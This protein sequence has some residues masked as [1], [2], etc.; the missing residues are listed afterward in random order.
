MN[1]YLSFICVIAFSSS[2]LGQIDYDK[3]PDVTQTYFINDVHIQK[4][5]TDSFG[6]GD[7]LIVD[8]YIKQVAKSISPPADA[9]IIEA[10]SAY[11]YSA[12]IDA[13]SYTGIPKPEKE[14]GRPKVKFPGNPPNDIAGITPEKSAVDILKADEGSI[15]MM[16]ESGFAI[17]HVVP[18]GR[19]LPGKGALI[20]LQGDDEEAM[21]LKKDHSM[22]FQFQGSRGV[23]P[24]TIIG[25]MS[26]W[27]DLYKNAELLNKHHTTYKTQTLG[28]KRPKT[29]KSLEALI[30]VTQRQMPVYMKAEKAK[31]IYRGL[32]LKKEL[33]YN[34]VLSNVKQIDP[35]ID[36]IKSSGA[37]VLL[38]ASTP[39]KDKSKGDKKGEGKDKGKGKMKKDKKPDSKKDMASE[40][41][42]EVKEEDPETKAL[43]ERKRKSYEAYVSQAAK[44]E[45]MNIPFAFSFMDAKVKD[46]KSTLKTLMEAG[47]SQRGA[48]AAL[49]TSPA[50]ILGID[51]VAGTLE[52]GKFANIMITTE[53]YFNES[54]SIKYIFVEGKMNE[55]EVKKKKEKKGEGGEVSE[56]LVGKWSYEID[57]P[58]GIQKGEIKIDAD[59]KIE[60][61]NESMGGDAQVIEDATYDG[62][63][64]TFSFSTSME[65]MELDLD[66]NLDLADDVLSGNVSVGEWGTYEMTGSKISSPE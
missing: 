5:P 15:K 29:D 64:V 1:R 10:D 37:T 42:K 33:G 21:V 22:F 62:T 4:S 54:S 9:Q 38:S 6:L 59:G 35:A 55:L 41:D 34:L 56:S 7:I 36:K 26:K 27:R 40:K 46:L 14:E 8:G 2:L 30:P 13:M 16:R 47:L 49:T 60:M 66:Y 12:F 43:K 3:V 45:K 17:S 63:N 44:L 52:P 53:P 19:M 18:R 61:T 48:L 11:A 24:A 31:D 28:T 39:K 51:K 20:S 50:K 25:V 23:F 57:T 65:S 58:M 32:E